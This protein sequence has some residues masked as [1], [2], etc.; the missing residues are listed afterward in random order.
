MNGTTGNSPK[1]IKSINPATL[2]V[3]AELPAT[4]PEAI[5]DIVAKA[6]EAQKK[7]AAVG[8]DK[9]IELLNR[10]R[11]YVIDNADELA[12]NITQDNG[13]TIFESLNAEIMSMLD[14][15][16][17]IAKN[18]AKVLGDEKLKNTIFSMSGIKSKNV[19][20][21][22]GV[23]FVI[24]PWN[25]PFANVWQELPMALAAGNA[26]IH[27]PAGIT[28][29]SG[30]LTRRIFEAIGAPEGLVTIVQGNG[31]VLGEAVLKHGVDNVV[32]T[33]SVPV[34][35]WLMAKCAE[36]LTPIT[37]ELGGNDPFIVLDDAN[38]ERAAEGAVWS[39][40]LNAGQVCASAERFYVHEKVFDKFIEIV[41]ART[42]SLRL[43]NGLDVNTD[44]GPL[45]SEDQLGI[46]ESHVK[47]AVEKGAK[48]AA[49][50]NRWTGLPGWFH[51]PTVLTG[52][53]H[54]ML[55]MKEETFGP[56]MPVMRFATDDEAVCLANDSQYGLTASVWTNSESRAARFAREVETGTITFNT[57]MLTAGFSVC[58]W[59]G[60]KDS[61]IGRV[62]SAYGLK[63]QTNI[64]N[65]TFQKALLKRDFWW[66]PYGQKK[67]DGMKAMI[68]TL[69]SKGAGKRISS[70][71]TMVR[72][73][74]SAGKH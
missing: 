21:P 42:K 4:N 69:H 14:T 20:E 62:H 11:Q 38:I 39:A 48:L 64:K 3:N 13:K 41:T 23:S 70:M 74:L 18:A 67:Y 50:G 10:A 45:I 65:V 24:S 29:L 46:V 28:A 34:G 59:G 31:S 61:G 7:W 47:D 56:T 19:F 8:L 40:F 53:D 43:G 25:F 54:S 15:V 44:M 55:C 58:P 66:Y 27:K 60:V 1:M 36:T 6:R 30:D 35:K 5:V 22:M 17:F 68:H 2:E 63:G 9:R 51:E 12:R 16:D 26:V 71:A 52:V 72:S 32:F 37:L 33:G 49:G 57:H 73:F